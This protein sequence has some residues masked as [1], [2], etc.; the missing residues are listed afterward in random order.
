[1]F[2]FNMLNFSFLLTKTNQEI[3]EKPVRILGK[4]VELRAKF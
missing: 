1:M 4:V 2:L 3:A